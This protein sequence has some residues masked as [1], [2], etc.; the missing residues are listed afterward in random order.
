MYWQKGLYALQSGRGLLTLTVVKAKSV[1]FPQLVYSI[2][3][4]IWANRDGCSWVCVYPAGLGF[5][6]R[7]MVGSASGLGSRLHLRHLLGLHGFGSHFQIKY[8]SGSVPC[9]IFTGLFRF[10]YKFL[11][12]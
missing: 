12:P 4:A 1:F 2:C 11:D 5:N 10:G 8:G 6:F 9:S 7:I 3:C